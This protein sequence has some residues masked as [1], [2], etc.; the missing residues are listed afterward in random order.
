MIKAFL[1]FGS[2][3]GYV[4]LGF[5]SLLLLVSFLIAMAFVVVVFIPVSVA[6]IFWAVLRLIAST[7]YSSVF[8]FTLDRLSGKHKRNA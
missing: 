5:F 1:L 8:D 4:A 2:V 6:V 3:L 7:L